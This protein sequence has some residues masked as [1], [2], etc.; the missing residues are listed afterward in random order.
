ML[1]HSGLT[2]FQTVLYRSITYTDAVKV[3]SW[4]NVIGF[5]HDG[6]G[7]RL[8]KSY[9]ESGC[10]GGPEIWRCCQADH[11]VRRRAY[12]LRERRRDGF[13]DDTRVRLT[14]NIMVKAL[15]FCRF[16]SVG[17]S[18]N[19]PS[20][21]CSECRQI[22]QRLKVENIIY[23]LIVLDTVVIIIRIIIII[24]VLITY[25]YFPWMLPF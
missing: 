23:Y 19:F 3:P 22:S 1:V 14:T 16:N 10:G 9:V 13:D 15:H 12:R 17:I 2:G 11:I 21:Y 20:M 8:G 25:T 5:D 6:A 18:N 7:E 4:R 24:F